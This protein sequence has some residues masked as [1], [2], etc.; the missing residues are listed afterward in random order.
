MKKAEDS[1]VGYFTKET[2]FL[3]FGYAGGIQAFLQNKTDAFGAL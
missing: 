2:W 3:S 1:P